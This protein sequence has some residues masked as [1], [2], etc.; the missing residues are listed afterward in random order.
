M[1]IDSTAYTHCNTPTAGLFILQDPSVEL[2][3]EEPDAVDR[4]STILTY[5]HSCVVWADKHLES[6]GCEKETHRSN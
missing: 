3:D 6:T 1:Y 5:A 4:M 2:A